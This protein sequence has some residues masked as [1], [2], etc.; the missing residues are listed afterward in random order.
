MEEDEGTDGIVSRGSKTSFARD[1][2]RRFQRKGTLTHVRDSVRSTRSGVLSRGSSA[3]AIGVA[4]EDR[5][6]KKRE[7]VVQLEEITVINS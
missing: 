6:D 1:G 7:E 5:V 3:T 4:D 2:S